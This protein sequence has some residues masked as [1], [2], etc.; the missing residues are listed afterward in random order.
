VPHLCLLVRLLL[1][2]LKHEALEVAVTTDVG[3][4]WA[5]YVCAI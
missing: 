1:C 2:L 4:G 3:R 5:E